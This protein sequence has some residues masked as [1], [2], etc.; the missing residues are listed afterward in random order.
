MTKNANVVCLCC[1]GSYVKGRHFCIAE[2][3]T[4]GKD[5]WHYDFC[6]RSM[7]LLLSSFRGQF[8]KRLRLE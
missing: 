6:Q 2:C 1:A 4:D 5:V 8:T 7:E 3:H